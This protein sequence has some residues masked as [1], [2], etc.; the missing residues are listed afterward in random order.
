[1]PNAQSAIRPWPDKRVLAVLIIKHNAELHPPFW[2]NGYGAKGKRRG[3]MGTT[4][5]MHN[6]EH[7]INPRSVTTR[8]NWAN[9]S[10][11]AEV[12][13]SSLYG[14]LQ[15][16]AILLREA[17]VLSEILWDHEN[18]P[19]SFFQALSFGIIIAKYINCERGCV[20]G[21]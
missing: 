8:A 7:G 19:E 6:C 9:S 12:R 5:I 2:A 17:R 3:A 11:A 14:T 18:F 15:G 13:Y 1:M 16:V 20:R 4:G 21:L 10:Q